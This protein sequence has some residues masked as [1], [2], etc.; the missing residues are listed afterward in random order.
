VGRLVNC[1]GRPLRTIQAANPSTRDQF[2]RWPA[3]CPCFNG[4]IDRVPTSCVTDQFFVSSDDVA[5]EFLTVV[6]VKRIRSRRFSRRTGGADKVHCPRDADSSKVSELGSSRSSREVANL[7]SR[8][9]GDDQ[10][11]SHIAIVVA[12]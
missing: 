6:S 1:S 8:D 7:F 5:A 4:R 12:L 10:R 11:A 3:S 2:L 9:V